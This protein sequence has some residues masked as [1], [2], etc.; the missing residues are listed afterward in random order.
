MFRFGL[1]AISQFK[2]ELHLWAKF[3][4]RALAIPHLKSVDAALCAYMEKVVR[5]GGEG[6]GR[7]AADGDL[8]GAA[9]GSATGLGE[10]GS[11]EA[12]AAA[13]AD[14]KQAGGSSSGSGGRAAGNV[15]NGVNSSG[16]KGEQQQ[17]AAGGG[18]GGKGGNAANGPADKGSSSSGPAKSA[19]AGSSST[20]KG[21]AGGSA[22]VGAGAGASGSMGGGSLDTGENLREILS[23]ANVAQA[24]ATMALNDKPTQFERMT[25][26]MTLNNETLD[27]A[28]RKHQMGAT[29]N[30]T[31]SDKVG[32]G[33]EAGWFG[34]LGVCC[35]CA[36]AALRCYR[37]C[38]TGASCT[39]TLAFLACLPC[40]VLSYLHRPPFLSCPA[41]LLLIVCAVSL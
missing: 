40:V 19:G 16:S 22:S 14:S 28:E 41:C 10:G 27:T 35:C 11:A 31:L 12:A 5:S 9:S 38:L 8:T 26:N 29:P 3:C 6:S 25:L 32:C 18:R 13:G 17:Q 15:P 4:E 24:A 39:H 2:P 34:Q 21:A 36:M 30:D 33:S 23:N 20:S 1:G 7:A 37:C